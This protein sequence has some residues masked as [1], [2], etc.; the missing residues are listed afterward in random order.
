MS[1]QG[2]SRHK[3]N[4]K[5]KNTEEMK[6]LKK[7]TD[8]ENKHQGLNKPQTGSQLVRRKLSQFNKSNK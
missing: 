8:T 1:E 4:I 3:V 7:M 6:K 5:H 2:S